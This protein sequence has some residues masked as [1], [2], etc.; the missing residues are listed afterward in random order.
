MRYRVTRRM[1]D[2]SYRTEVRELTPRHA[3]CTARADG[4]VRVIPVIP[5]YQQETPEVRYG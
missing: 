2:G 3:E 4:V 1:P 5:R